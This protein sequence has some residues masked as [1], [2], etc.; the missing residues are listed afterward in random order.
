[1]NDTRTQLIDYTNKDYASL[2][3]AMLA[4]ASEKLPE[5][6]DHSPNDLGVVLIELLAAMGDM[7]AYYQD[8]IADESYLDTAVE[9]RSVMN[10]LRLIGYEL[11]PPQPASADLFLIFEHDANKP[12]GVLVPTQAEFKTKADTRSPEVSFRY[13]RDDLAI[14]VG[15]LPTLSDDLIAR[16]GIDSARLPFKPDDGKDYRLYHPLPVVQVDGQ[17]DRETVG[18]SDGSPGQ[19]FALKQQPLIEESLQV[20]VGEGSAWQRRESLLKSLSGDEHFTVRRDEQGIAWIEFGDGKFGRIPPG[21]QNNIIASYRIGGGNQGNV[22]AYSIVQAPTIQQLKAVFN[23][24][25][26]AGGTEAES[27]REAAQRAPHLFRSMGR[28]VTTSDYEE[29]ARQFGVGKVRA[30][31]SSQYTPGLSRVDLVVA[32]AGG[33]YPSATLKEDLNAYFA[34]KRAVTTALNIMDPAYVGVVIE[35]E[36][37]VE[38]YYFTDQVRQQAEQAVGRLLAFDK[39]DFGRPLYLSKVYQALEA[40]DGVASVSVTCF[41]YREDDRQPQLQSKLSFAWNELP[42]SYYSAGI[43]FNTVTGGQRDR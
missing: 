34:D 8:R 1:V 43:R 36:L 41:D 5:W 15:Q 4:L 12:A 30:V 25:P 19:R 14:D 16:L 11:R 9:P 33:G 39:V 24:N 26:A 22:A 18:S 29:F 23:P 2:R 13:V 40:I 20:R 7:L 27:G 42:T 35:G 3:E 28:A 38:P 21:G 32:P 10:L 31:A 6:T 37:E 17:V